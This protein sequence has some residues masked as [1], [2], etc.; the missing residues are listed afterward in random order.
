MCGLFGWQYPTDHQPTPEQRTIVGV[1][2]A[3]RMVNRGRDACG[4]ATEGEDKVVY[5]DKDTRE[6]DRS[7]L[8]LAAVSNTNLIGHTRFATV[9]KKTKDNAHPFWIGDVVGAH[10][11]GIYNHSELSKSY[12]ERKDYEVDSMHLIAHISEEKDCEELEGY[13]AVTWYHLKDP[14]AIYLCKMHRGDLEIECLPDDMGIIWASTR[15]AISESLTPACLWSKSKSFYPKAE[16]VYRVFNGKIEETDRKIVLK[17]FVLKTST[18]SST[19]GIKSNTKGNGQDYSAYGASFFGHGQT[20]GEADPPTLPYGQRR[21][22]AEK[23]LVPTRV[24][25]A[26]K[27]EEDAYKRAVASYD[28]DLQKSG[29][30]PSVVDI[31]T[32]GK[33]TPI[34]KARTSKLTNKERKKLGRL[35]VLTEHHHDGCACSPCL[36]VFRLAVMEGQ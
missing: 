35:L 13:G 6:F 32:G 14:G 25:G 29:L 16:V 11:G 4:F 36:Q 9:G 17:Q 21:Q 19:K 15:Y 12:P 23:M 24:I 20:G 31:T 18:C 27:E 10:N 22:L 33:V 3:T 30:A 5:F 1:S 34:R 7:H 8:M 2:L 26:T 28:R